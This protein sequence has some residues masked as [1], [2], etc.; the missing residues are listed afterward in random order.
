[1]PLS[2]KPEINRITVQVQDTDDLFDCTNTDSKLTTDELTD[3]EIE[4]K[5][6]EIDAITDIQ[7]QRL[8]ELIYK[9]KDIFR[10]AP[11]RFQSFEYKL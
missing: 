7:E 10:K 4:S 6:T 9:Y 1:M 11:G 2:T 3:E 5:L 8:R